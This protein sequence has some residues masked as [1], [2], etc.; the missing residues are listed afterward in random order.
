MRSAGC[1]TPPKRGPLWSDSPETQL[2]LNPHASM[3]DKR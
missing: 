1:A 2:S 3:P